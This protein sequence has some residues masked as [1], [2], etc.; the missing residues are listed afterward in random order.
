MKKKWILCAVISVLLT[1]SAL[2]PFGR[3]NEVWQETLEVSRTEQD[4]EKLTL[5]EP[6]KLHRG[7]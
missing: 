5:G 6:Q 2:L 1:G 7:I 4:R 3:K